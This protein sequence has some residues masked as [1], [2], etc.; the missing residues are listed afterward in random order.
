MN[1]PPSPRPSFASPHLEESRNSIPATPRSRTALAIVAV[2]GFA[3]IV[4]VASNVAVGLLLGVVMAFVA[5]PL[6][7]RVT[8]LL[9]GRARAAAFLTT[10]AVLLAVVAAAA[11]VVWA[12]AGEAVSLAM[13]VQQRVATVSVDRLVGPVGVHLLDALHIPRAWVLTHAQDAAT[14]IQSLAAPLVTGVVASTGVGAMLGVITFATMYYA[15]FQW[16]G[17][18]RRLEGLLPLRPRYTRV[19]LKEFESVGRGALLGTLGT[20]ACQGVLA[21]MGYIAAGV[22]RAPLWGLLTTAVSFLP[23]GG[24]LLVWVPA[25]LYLASVNRLG[26]AVGL[27]AWSLLVVVMLC[28]YV[29][30][31]RLIGSSTPVHPL[32]VLVA[33]LGGV[34]TFGLWGV[35]IGPV[36]MSVCVAA[37]R[38]YETEFAQNRPRQTLV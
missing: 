15:L 24:T 19:L 27:L 33:L 21:T 26:A 20:S 23:V 14:R 35:L 16:S 30:R 6:F 2:L 34:E 3:A 29:V 9:R 38:L 22:P 1:A 32:L 28:D 8:A 31:P 10:S 4:Y 17:V 13:E 25:T 5:E 36:L 11:A 12:V 7:R 37:L 18:S